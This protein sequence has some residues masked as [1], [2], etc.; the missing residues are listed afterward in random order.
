MRVEEFLIFDLRFY[1]AAVRQNAGAASPVRARSRTL[2]SGG[3]GGSRSRETSDALISRMHGLRSP[4]HAVVAAVRQNAGDALPG[5]APIS[6][7]IGYP[8]YDHGCAR[9]RI[10]GRTSIVEFRKSKIKNQK[11]R[12]AL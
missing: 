1:V 12:A 10:A 5:R 7:E 3:Y 9:C 8:H 2:A 11:I 4:C 6:G